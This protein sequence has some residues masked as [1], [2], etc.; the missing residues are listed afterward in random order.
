M[1]SNPHGA[2]RREGP[3]NVVRTHTYAQKHSNQSVHG[4]ADT[5]GHKRHVDAFAYAAAA[6]ATGQRYLTVS[7]SD[8]IS[9]RTTKEVTRAHRHARLLLHWQR[10][11]CIRS[12]WVIWPYV[13]QR[14][15]NGVC[16]CVWANALSS[17]PVRADICKLGLHSSVFFFFLLFSLIT[18]RTGSKQRR[19]SSFWLF[20]LTLFLKV[21]R[22]A[23]AAELLTRSHLSR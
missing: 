22:R 19:H 13:R 8:V 17:L 18:I 3:F 7:R 16:L 12:V 14:H 11:A 15:Q 5:Q 23:A 9:D 6:T 10:G 4:D 2:I 21:K 20:Y 1:H